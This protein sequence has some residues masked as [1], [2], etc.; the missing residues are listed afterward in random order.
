MQLIIQNKKLLVS[1]EIRDSNIIFI[2]FSDL[3]SYDKHLGYALIKKMGGSHLSFQALEADMY[4]S[5]TTNTFKEIINDIGIEYKFYYFYGYSSGGHAAIYFASSLEIKNKIVLALSPLNSLHPGMTQFPLKINYTLPIYKFDL[6]FTAKNSIII[7]DSLFKRDSTFVNLNYTNKLNCHL[8]TFPKTGHATLRA[9]ISNKKI[10]LIFIELM[11]IESCNEKN[12]L[13]LAVNINLI[14]KNTYKEY[15]KSID[16][17]I[18][19]CGELVHHKKKYFLAK[20]IFARKILKRI[21]ESNCQKHIEEKAYFDYA[22]ALFHLKEF[23]EAR[24]YINKAIQ[25]KNNAIYEKLLNEILKN[26]EC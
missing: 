21:S 24:I 22:V 15:R 11:K 18:L 13:D 4:Q 23:K 5:L 8:I 17:S 7:Y 12:I 9:L 16:R 14:I 2:T 3:E 19:L 25:I 20:N 10:E 6:N 1:L 26:C